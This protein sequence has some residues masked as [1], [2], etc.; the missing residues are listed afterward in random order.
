M[1]FAKISHITYS[2]ESIQIKS[3]LKS[4]HFLSSMS[5]SRNIDMRFGANNTV[6]DFTEYCVRSHS[7]FRERQ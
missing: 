5:M 6:L 2:L 7:P 1:K 3:S 4:F